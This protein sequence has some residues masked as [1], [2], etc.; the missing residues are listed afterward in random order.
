MR[1]ASASTRPGSRA[2]LEAKTAI[3]P[4]QPEAALARRVDEG[5][6]GLLVRGAYGHSRIRPLLIGST[7]TE[8]IR[9]CRIP[10]V[11]VR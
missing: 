8:M 1:V 7:T 5:Q 10:V 2:G 9:S 6:C 11:L 3:L 4:G